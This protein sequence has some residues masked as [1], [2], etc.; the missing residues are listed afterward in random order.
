ME[1]ELLAAQHKLD[2]LKL[3]STKAD[4]RSQMFQVGVVEGDSSVVDGFVCV[5]TWK[6][7]CCWQGAE[8]CLA[9][10]GLPFV[11]ELLAGLST[12]CSVKME[13]S[14]VVCFSEIPCPWWAIQLA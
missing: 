10:S 13:V 3:D 1:E 9:C 5:A 4:I 2:K 12:T 11:R 14:F 6:R 7:L 8:R